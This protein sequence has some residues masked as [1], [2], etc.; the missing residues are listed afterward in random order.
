MSTDADNG[1]AG[2]I[3][4][5]RR[6]FSNL[7]TFR[8][9]DTRRQFWCF[10]LPVI[11]VGIFLFVMIAIPT[12]FGEILSSVSQAQE[13]ARAHP[14]DWVVTRSPGSVHYNYVGD[15]PAVM[16]SMMPDFQPLL[17]A[18]MLIGFV[19]VVL[20]AAAVTRRL[21]DRGHSGAWALV[22]AILLMLSAMLMMRLIGT[23][24]STAGSDAADAISG[25][26]AVFATNILYLASLIT[27][28]IQCV[29]PGD[30]GPNR[31]GEPPA[32]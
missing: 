5:A 16:A 19:V 8:G 9:R 25:F 4:L 29:M 30:A 3:A 17:T 6:G 10:A 23:F 31:F 7:V 24:S 2:V 15:D 26:F 21:H 12:M 20:L 11:G 28:V 22:P 27:L 13:M 18:T 1:P 32:A 14:Q